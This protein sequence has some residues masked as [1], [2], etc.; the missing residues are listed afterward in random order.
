LGRGSLWGNPDPSRHCA[1]YDATL[2]WRGRHRNR[3]SS[4]FLEFAGTWG[5]ILVDSEFIAEVE[6][7]AAKAIAINPKASRAY[8]GRC[9]AALFRRNYDRA[10][11][12]CKAAVDAQPSDDTALAFYGLS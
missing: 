3:T 12:Q 1:A 9:V 10:V 4:F 6:G 8:V 2:I 11:N 5:C 7:F